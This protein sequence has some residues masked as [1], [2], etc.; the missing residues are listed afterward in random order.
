MPYRSGADKSRFRDR[1][2]QLFVTSP[3]IGTIVATR[4][5]MVRRTAPARESKNR[6]NHQGGHNVLIGCR[7]GTLIA[8]PCTIRANP[9]PIT[10]K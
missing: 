4:G 2:H 1:H 7:R 3:P 10:L 8:S 5:P 6:A 9:R